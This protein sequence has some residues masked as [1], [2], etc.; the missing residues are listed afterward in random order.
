MKKFVFIC[1]LCFTIL[2]C[3]ADVSDYVQ[4]MAQAEQ[5]GLQCNLNQAFLYDSDDSDSQNSDDFYN[6]MIYQQ[7]GSTE[8]P[9]FNNHLQMNPNEAN[10]GYQSN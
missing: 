4:K 6:E 5:R 8:S 2:P 7:Y 3:A 9:A 10:Y 1:L